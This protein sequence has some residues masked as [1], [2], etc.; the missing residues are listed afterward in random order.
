MICVRVLAT[1]GAVSADERLLGSGP[2]LRGVTQ[3][4]VGVRDQQMGLADRFFHSDFGDAR[5]PVEAVPISRALTRLI[6]CD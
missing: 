1:E 4:H 6:S 3:S 5:L 2:T